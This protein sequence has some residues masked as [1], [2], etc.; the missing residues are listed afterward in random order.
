MFASVA[1]YWTFYLILGLA[2]SFGEI[3]LRH[4]AEGAGPYRRP[5]S[6]EAA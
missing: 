3:S 1:Y 6:A 4:A 2:T 5:L